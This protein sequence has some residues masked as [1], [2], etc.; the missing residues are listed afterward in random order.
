MPEFASS[1][2]SYV[3]PAV[4][5]VVGAIVLA[6][7]ALIRVFREGSRKY[8]GNV[9][10]EYD[11]WTKEGIL[12][13]YWGEHIHLGYYSKEERQPGFFAWGKKDFKQVRCRFCPMNR[14]ADGSMWGACGD[15]LQAKYDFIDE[16]LKWSGAAEPT[17]V[18]DVGCGFGGTSRMLAAKYGNATVDGIT[19][20]PEQV[21]RGTE[22]AEERCGSLPFCV[23]AAA[24]R[25][26]S[27]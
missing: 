5:A 25:G 11:A 20:S 7:A 27:L 13:Y 12:E 10:E 4:V 21:K 14:A 1:A 23:T 18:L 26:R 19:L 9:G 3:T 15:H 6:L 2:L 24:A 16:M 22:L 17:K 8:D